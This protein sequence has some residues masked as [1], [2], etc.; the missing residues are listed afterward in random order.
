MLAL[1]LAAACANVIVPD[2]T[3]QAMRYYQSGN[4]VWIL[5]QLWMLGIPLLI[6]FTGFSAKLETIAKRWTKNWYLSLVLYLALFIGVYQLLSFPLDFYADYIREHQFYLS[7]QPFGR[8]LGNY[9]KTFIVAVAAAGLFV[10]IFYL[11]LKKSPRRWWI[12]SSITTI[13]ITFFLMFVQPIWIDPLFNKFGPMKNKELENQILTLAARAGIQNGRVFEVDKSKDTQKLN[14]YVVGFGT[15]NR[16]VLWDTTIREMDTDQILF[17]MGHEMGH[18]I[19]HHNWWLLIYLSALS[20]LIF[21]LTYRSAH[22]LLHRYKKCFGF[23]HL[24]QFASWPLL[25]FLASLFLL[26][27]L[28]LSNFVYR[29]I[30]HEADRFGLEITQNN[31]VA[32][33]AF[34]TLQRENLANPRPGLLYKIWRCTHPPLVERVDFCNRYC[35][36]EEGKPLKYGKYF[37]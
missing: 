19:L 36:W 29:Y 31:E 32:G 33:Q 20:F 17:V 28:P 24:Y 13:G 8:W 37:K 3:E 15:T 16:I 10:W 18:Y 2:A 34:L 12:Y 9:G 25:I 1:F 6:L 5:Q 4:I 23:K 30:E 35:P 21:Y 26:L 14:A 7:T 27:S 11:L 22:F